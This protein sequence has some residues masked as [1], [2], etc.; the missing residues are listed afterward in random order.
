M[1][2]GKAPTKTYL[3]DADFLRTNGEAARAGKIHRSRIFYD[4]HQKAPAGFGVRFRKDGAPAYVLNYYVKGAE[5]RITIKGD[6]SALSPTAARLK[7]SAIYHAAREGVDTLA[8]KRAKDAAEQ[9][10]KAEASRKKD[11]TLA[12]LM[13]AYVEQQKADGRA[14]WRKVEGAFRRNI[15]EPFPKLAAKPADEVNVDDVMPALA[16]MA[17]A[18]HVRG[19]EQLRVYMRAAYNSAKRARH[20]AGKHAFAKFKITSNPLA[21]LEFTRA[22]RNASAAGIRALSQAELAAYW[23]RIEADSTPRGAALRLHLLTGGQ[24]AEQ[25]ARLSRADYDADRKAITLRDTKG[26]RREAYEHGVPLLPEA[27][28]AIEVLGARFPAYPALRAAL[29]EHAAAMVKAGEVDRVFTPGTIRKT[30]ETRLAAA[31]VPDEVLARL[32]SHGLGGVQ[33]RHYNAHKYDEEKRAALGT[34]R[35]ML[36]P[37]PDNVTP[38]RRK[39]QKGV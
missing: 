9:A 19:P 14:D 4:A 34:L 31:G 17:K 8:I 5:R 11:L 26:R 13:A 37:K 33:A 27:V 18:G 36:D 16:A 25:L 30:V 10:T 3:I 38:I 21:D 20:D 32:L 6:A 22:K 12:A 28:D 35:A 2:P 24:R 7:A 29:Q 23:R 1:A 39:A 15:A